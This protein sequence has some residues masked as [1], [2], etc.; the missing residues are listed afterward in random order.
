MRHPI[1]STI[2]LIFLTLIV[3]QLSVTIKSENHA[4]GLR[5]SPEKSHLDLQYWRGLFDQ[6]EDDPPLVASFTRA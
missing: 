3:G 4:L 1:S 5:N 2:T 6:E